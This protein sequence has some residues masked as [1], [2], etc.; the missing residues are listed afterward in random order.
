MT[1]EKCVQ[2][3]TGE[4]AIPEKQSSLLS[5]FCIPGV[6]VNCKFHIFYKNIA[7]PKI[8]ISIEAG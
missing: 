7:S 1:D 3:A 4:E 6:F 2:E 5:F 8:Y